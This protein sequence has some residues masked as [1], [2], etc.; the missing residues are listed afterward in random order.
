MR[1]A[2]E[3]EPH[4]TGAESPSPLLPQKTVPR[5]A[6]RLNYCSYA[7]SGVGGI[8]F[9]IPPGIGESGHVT[10]VSQ[11]SELFMWFCANTSGFPFISWLTRLLLLPFS[12]SSS[13][14]SPPVFTFSLRSTIPTICAAEYPH[15]PSSNHR[16][17]L[18]PPRWSSRAGVP[19]GVCHLSHSHK[20]PGSRRLERSICS[21]CVDWPIISSAWIA[22]HTLRVF[23]QNAPE[24]PILTIFVPF[25]LRSIADPT[26]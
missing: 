20:I 22:I 12:P 10:I 21:S 6:A 3:G 16:N 11:R 9:G 2:K 7:N 14:P 8:V 13:I 26:L 1:K 5:N 19:L 25:T 15:H 17:I 24:L 4:K 23:H 18:C